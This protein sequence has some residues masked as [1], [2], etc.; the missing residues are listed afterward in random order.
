LSDLNAAKPIFSF[1]RR[2]IPEVIVNG[3]CCFKGQDQ[4]PKDPW[5]DA[6]LVTRSLLKPWQIVGSG[7]P[8]DEQES[9]WALGIASHSGQPNHQEFLLKL[10]RTLKINEDE[11]VCP[12]VYA[13]DP[14]IAAHE[15]TNGHKPSRMQHPCAGKHLFLAAAAKLSGHSDHHYWEEQHPT[16]KKIQGLVGKE[17]SEKVQWVTDS[18]GLPVAAM[19]V[20]ALMN[21]YERMALDASGLWAPLLTLWTRNPRLIGGAKRLDSDIVE[22]FSGRLIAKEGADGLLMVQSLPNGQDS[23]GGVFIKIASGYNASHLALALWCTL[24]A[25]PALPRV[26]DELRSYLTSRL[27]EWVPKDQQIVNLLMHQS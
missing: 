17:A 18:C 27:E 6:A 9:M 5:F 4:L 1:S 16:Q 23:V 11:L 22:S 24:S 26:F 10:S 20:R 12:R 2:Q 8:I 14:L 3:I 13:M 25:R 7:M 19:S 21:M 15:R